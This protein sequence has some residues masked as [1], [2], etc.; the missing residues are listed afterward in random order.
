[1]TVTLGELYVDQ[2]TGFTGMATARTVY[3]GGLVS[4]LLEA[5]HPEKAVERWFHEPRLKPLEFNGPGTYA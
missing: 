5:R 4:V 1:M 2:P 3:L